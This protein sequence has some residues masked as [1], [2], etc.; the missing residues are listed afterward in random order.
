M[1]ARLPGLMLGLLC[2]CGAA[3]QPRTAA[4][5]EQQLIHSR[6]IEA[7]IW[8]MP[9]VNYD[10]MFQQMVSK[11]GGKANQIVYWSRLPDWKNQTLTPNPDSIYLMPFFNTK[12]V[13]PV[14]IEI[15][16]ADEGSIN[17]TIM[18]IW[19]MPLEDVGPA[20]VDKGKGGK[21][22]ILPPG[23][24]NPPPAGYIAL[25]SNTYQGYALLRSILKSGS[26]ADVAQAV[27]Y[28]RRVEIYPLSQA[29]STPATPFVDAIDVV[30]DAT[31]PYDVRF[32]ESLDRVVQQEP[33][34]ERDRAMI[35]QL[36]SVGIVRGT[37]FAPDEKTRSILNTAAVEA[38]DL[39]ESRYTG[40]FAN[41]YYDDRRWALPAVPEYLTAAMNGFADAGS[42]PVDAR[43]LFF[44]YAFFTAKHLGEG[45]FYM[46]T[47]TDKD[48]HN[49]DGANTYRLNVPAN[50]PVT[51]YWSATA[52]DRANH[53][54][55][56]DQKW[57]SRSSQS[58][59]LRTNSDGSVDIYFGPKAPAGQ[60]S[61]WVPTDPDG[62]FEILFRFYGPEKALFDKTWKLSDVEKLP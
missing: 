40:L 13:G 44:T 2:C 17:G 43:G 30:F 1:N 25:P 56:R 28:A 41:Y 32:F 48:G 34:L 54:L 7:V 58:P 21:Y 33:W 3:A 37:P 53:A 19:Q 10:L 4:E 47:L 5:L 35:D 22:L 51:L 29:A 62:E 55:I 45:Q 16:P 14:V 11:A 57:S 6:A 18:D 27:A 12:D 42:Y 15:P 46:M 23:Y 60:E 49:L 39:L 59:K 50:A 38:R 26:A 20:G 52:Y 8:G 61:N 31:I 9:V 36:K 24:K